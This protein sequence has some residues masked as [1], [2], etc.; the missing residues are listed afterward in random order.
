[1]TVAAP[2]FSIALSQP[3]TKKQVGKG[4]VLVAG[5]KS[6]K[7]IYELLV[8]DE[9]GSASGSGILRAKHAA[10]K[11]MWLQPLATLRLSNG[12]RIYI[13]ITELKSVTAKFEIVAKSKSR[14]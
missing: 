9:P 4:I 5:I 1:M 7:V 13:S 8:N 3:R 10:L 14:T 11:R 12:Q 6:T 2:Y